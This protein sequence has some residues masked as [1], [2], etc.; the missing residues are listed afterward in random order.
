MIGAL[1]SLFAN[2]VHVIDNK[3]HGGLPEFPKLFVIHIEYG[4]SQD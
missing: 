1:Y 4:W 3:I 2:I